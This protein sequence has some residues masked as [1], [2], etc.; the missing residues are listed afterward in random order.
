MAHQ[1]EHRSSVNGT[2]HEDEAANQSVKLHIAADGDE[3]G[4]RGANDP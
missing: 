3:H 4:F 2:T 1:L